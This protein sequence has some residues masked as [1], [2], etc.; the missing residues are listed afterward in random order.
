MYF[1]KRKERP[2]FSRNLGIGLGVQFLLACSQQ[3]RAQAYI[4]LFALGGWS[5]E[6]RNPASVLFNMRWIN[7]LVVGLSAAVLGPRNFWPE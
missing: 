2:E 4:W 1:W 5:L 7:D 3:E 6:K